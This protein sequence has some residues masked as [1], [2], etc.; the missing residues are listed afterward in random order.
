MVAIDLS[1]SAVARIRVA[2]SCLWEVVA[3]LRVL[4]H[5]GLSI[6]Q[7]YCSAADVADGGGLVHR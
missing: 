4:R 5:P 1:A 2:V 3:S 7:R 6:N